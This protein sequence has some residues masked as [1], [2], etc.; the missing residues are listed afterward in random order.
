MKTGIDLITEE[1]E[2]QIREEGWTPEH[3]DGHRSGELNDA[4]TP[5]TDAEEFYIDCIID[6]NVY[7]HHVVRPSFARRLERERNTAQAEAEKWQAQAIAHQSRHVE[8][9]TKM[10]EELAALTE[11]AECACDIF[12]QLD[13][14]TWNH[15]GCPV[16][17]KEAQKFLIETLKKATGTTVNPLDVLRDRLSQADDLLTEWAE[18]FEG[19][20]D[21]AP[22]ASVTSKAVGNLAQRYKEVFGK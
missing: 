16:A 9:L 17:Y 15:D 12:D 11:A 6:G 20:I 2:R 1:R 14:V 18:L 5:E 13:A 7:E 4:A 3:D 21:G 19:Y 22:D 8:E 10:R